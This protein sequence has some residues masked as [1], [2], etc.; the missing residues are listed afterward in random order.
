MLNLRVLKSAVNCVTLGVDLQDQNVARI[1]RARRSSGPY[2]EV[3]VADGGTHV[4]TVDLEP[5]KTYYYHAV[6][7]RLPHLYP[8]RESSKGIRPVAATVPRAPREKRVTVTKKRQEFAVT[9]GG[10]LDESNSVTMGPEVYCP[11]PN[12]SMPPYDQAFE[13]NLYVTIEN[14]GETDLINPWVVAN[15]QRDW[16]SVETMVREV[17]GKRALTEA[18]KMMAVWKFVVDEVYDSRCGLS[19]FDDLSDPVKLFN[20][21]GFE[22]CVG[23]A[24]ATSRLAEEMGVKAREVW[25][26]GVL[27]GHGRGR[28]CSHTIFEACGD[29]AWHLL[30]TDQMLFFLK[31][32]NRTVAGVEDLAEDVDL[33]RRTHRNLGLAGKDLAEKEF[34]ETQFRERE[35]VYPPN[36]SGAWANQAGHMTQGVEER[37]PPHTMALRLRPGEKLVRYWDDAGKTVVRGRRLH[38]DVRFSNGKLV[39]QPDL[40]WPLALKGTE[41]RSNLKQ[42]KAGK[43]PALHPKGA[44]EISEVVWKV[45]SPYAI[46]GARVGLTCRRESREDGLEVLFSK[47]GR[48]WRSVW[49]ASG[50]RMEACVGLDWYVNP[51][52]NDWREERDL[53][54]RMGPCYQFYIKVAMWAGSHPDAVGLDS[55][56]FDTDIQ[57]AT[58]SLPS[59]FCGKNRIVYRDETRGPRKARV[60]YGWQEEHSV[61]PPGTP[62]PLFPQPGADV[63][64]L[65]FEFHWHRPKGRGP[66]VDDYHIQVSR[67]ADF[68]WCVCPAFDR[69]VS[70]TG[71]AGKTC[72]QPQFPNLLNPDE[73][74]YWRVRARNARG[75]WGEWSRAFAFVPHGPRHPVELAVKRRGRG[76]ALTW[77]PHPEGN[78]PVGYR[79]YGSPEPGFSAGEDCLLGSVEEPCWPLKVAAGRRRMSYRVAAVD[80]NGVPSTPSGSIAG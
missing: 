21:Y 11:G 45:A 73:T 52:L 66:R 26:G 54:W 55:I 64:R 7:L 39:Y 23:Y 59:L 48:N 14:A 72:W 10:Y 68:R 40:R 58:R 4:D 22:G 12:S 50:D 67:Y 75:A 36:R 8:D 44:R 60:T 34:Y 80:A 33:I 5:G 38:P 6:S 13:P 3:G 37:P 19:W 49:M 57:C 32:D 78:R 16:W 77:S 42:E 79:V 29:G 20:V 35:F 65:D 62:E 76:R 53:G 18:E 61:R 70:R 31:R 28:S 17:V 30:D 41:S 1:Y 63:D 69:Y 24:V 71:Y 46:A 51:A 56:R 15:G 25:V 27:D 2:E 9:M 74:Y 43:R 47:D